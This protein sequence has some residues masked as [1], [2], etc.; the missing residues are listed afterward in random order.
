MTFKFGMLIRLSNT[1]ILDINGD[2]TQEL[3]DCRTGHHVVATHIKVVLKPLV[4]CLRAGRRDGAL[5]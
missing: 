1:K 2:P 3:G 5:A 4:G